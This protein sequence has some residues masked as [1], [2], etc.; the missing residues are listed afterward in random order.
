V[1]FGGLGRETA[2]LLASELAGGASEVRVRRRLAASLDL[3]LTHVAWAAALLAPVFWLAESVSSTTLALLILAAEA[4]VAGA[5]WLRTRQLIGLPE[6]ARS[7]AAAPAP[8][9]SVRAQIRALVALRLPPLKSLLAQIVRSG[10]DVRAALPRA[11]ATRLAIAPEA[12]ADLV[13]K[14]LAA[15]ARVE[16]YE[17]LLS[18]T[19]ASRL[20]SRL[21][22]VDLRLD[23]ANGMR[24]LDELVAEKARLVRD[25]KELAEVEDRHA[26]TMLSIVNAKSLLG[27]M[28][29]GLAGPRETDAIA[30]ELVE[31]TADLSRAPELAAARPEVPS[32]SEEE[33]ATSS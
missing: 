11:G 4:G 13:G 24:E 15:A 3:P 29:D 6:L 33:A 31:R 8:D 1:L 27:R 30:L 19:S 7:I 32:Y 25:L 21:A 10:L 2:E 23:A 9:P 20:R 18:G 14:A 28:E 5:Y 17:L 16:R 22:A 12:I 26:A